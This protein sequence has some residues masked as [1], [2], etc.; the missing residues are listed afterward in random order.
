MEGKPSEQAP[1]VPRPRRMSRKKGRIIAATIVI[2]VVAILVAFWGSQ[3]ARTYT[4]TDI[5]N[6]PQQFVGKTVQVRGLAM[7]V[8]TTNLTFVLGDLTKNLT[9]H[10][11]ALPT[12]FQLEVEMIVKGSVEMR[13]SEWAFVAQEVLVGHPK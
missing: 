6:A 1:A 7:A 4:P 2:I 9:V 8:N 12:G 3:P 10:Y 11:S 13:G 5:V